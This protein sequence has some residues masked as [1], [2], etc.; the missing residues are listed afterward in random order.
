[1][2]VFSGCTEKTRKAKYVFYFI[3]DGMGIN[4]VLAT[5]MYLAELEGQIGV[6]P[7]C[8]TDFPVRNHVSTYS[9]T[10]A[11]TCS[12]AAGTA[13][14]TG[15]KTQNGRIGM[16]VQK[17][18][19]ESIASKAK[20]AGRKV[21]ITTSVGINHATPAV[22]Y[23]H[24]PDREMY[25][26]I[27]TDAPKAGFDFYGGAGFKQVVSPKDSLLPDLYALLRTSGYNVIDS[28]QDF[29]E[30]SRH[31]DKVIYVQPKDC[32]NPS[33]LPAVLD[34]EQ[35]DLTLS[36]ITENAIQFLSGQENEG[37]FLMVEGGIID[38]L[39]HANDGAGAI[40]E[41]I[42]FSET[43]QK[44]YDFYKKHPDETLIVVTADHETGGLALGSGPYELHL[45]NLAYQKSS[46]IGLTQKLKQLR[47]QLGH[48]LSYQNIQE[49]L[50]DECGFGQDIILSENEERELKDC[51]LES[52]KNMKLDKSE[53]ALIDPVARVAVDIINRK[54]M[55]HWASGGH[56]AGVVPVYA[57]GVGAEEFNEITDNTDIPKLI[58]KIAGY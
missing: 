58:E 44:A 9:R 57:I 35:E 20:R 41:I 38:W 30:M 24:Q 8:F 37:F 6:H 43:I 21:G 4:Q 5:G 2:A 22:F 28:K 55:I 47:K 36:M 53:Y 23:A 40:R 46:I 12:A 10:N 19:L 25:Y 3:G 34:R 17:Q 32:K 45:K 14:A 15:V 33:S 29:S 50:H 26:E 13:L 48:Q 49:L 7:L 18:A 16:D 51:F 56:S 52:M 42:D 39:C 54:A 27:G 1:M 11:V 31:C